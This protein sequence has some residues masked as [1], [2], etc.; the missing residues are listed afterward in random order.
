M[1]SN[2]YKCV[3][4]AK[5]IFDLLTTGERGQFL[6]KEKNAYSHLRWQKAND[7]MSLKLHRLYLGYSTEIFRKRCTLTVYVKCLEELPCVN[8]FATFKIQ[9]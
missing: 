6:I 7:M 4:D 1:E 2:R 3:A 9:N 8:S 5:F